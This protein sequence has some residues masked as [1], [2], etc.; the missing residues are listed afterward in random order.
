MSD[1]ENRL[2]GLSKPLHLTPGY[3]VERVRQAFPILAE[4]IYGKPLIYLDSAATSQKP[5]AVID[6]MSHFFSKENA[7]VHRGVHYLSVRATEEYEKARAKV[8]G[9]L[10]TES[11]EEIVFVRGTTEAVNLVAQTYGKTQLRAGDEVLITAMEHHSNIVPW[12]MLCEQTGARLRVAPINDAGEL[13]LDELERL[14]GPRTRLVAVTH[15]SNVLGTINPIRRIVEL[16]HARGVRVLVDGAQA[17]P[18]LKVDVRALGCDFYALS[19]HKMYGPTGIGVLY[20]RHELLE[21]MPPYQGGGDMILSVSF[22]KTV[23][24]K[25]PYKFEAGTPNMAGAIGLG[26]A[27]D[28]LAE[29]GP[30]A[31]AAHE[32]AVQAYATKALAALP[33]LRLIGTA[34]EKVGVLSFVLDG[35]HPHD[36][37]TILDRE[38]IA[39]RTG[40]HCAQPLMN[41]FG[42]PATAR[43]SL[44]CY[45]T[46]RDID[47]LVAGLAKVQEVFR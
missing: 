26:A 9:F 46:E 28:F 37:G 32:Q 34:A 35:I 41:R 47:A 5:Q 17:A 7:N 15:V 29:L 19:G 10:N 31:I 12:Q 4:T 22:E 33:G 6:A 16:A 23:Y 40:H 20:G 27:I 1:L 24:N 2:Q 14:I 36:I 25:P 42:V 44:G 8:Q 13:L 3:D 21:S 11:V 39:I 30:G 45:S 43:A 38:G 18:H